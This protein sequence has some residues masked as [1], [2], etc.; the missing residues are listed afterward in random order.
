M[1]LAG[2]HMATALMRVSRLK[3]R[4]RQLS[5]NSLSFKTRQ[6][7]ETIMKSTTT[8]FVTLLLA[9]IGNTV[10]AADAIAI[11]AVSGYDV[12]SY[13]SESGPQ[14]GSGH[15]T[16]VHEGAIYQFTDPEN[17][18]AFDANPAHYVPAYG[19]FCAFGVSVGKKFNT[20]PL[21]WKLVDGR[22]YLN[23]DKDIQAQWLKDIPGKIAAADKHWQRIE[24]IAADQL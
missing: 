21:A 11:T 8:V 10:S 4:T 24:H 1:K 20:D 18:A 2:H 19:G 5:L 6:T 13:H 15:Y 16:S 7:K 23:L 3:M 22:L 9:L 12:V 14:R 17:K